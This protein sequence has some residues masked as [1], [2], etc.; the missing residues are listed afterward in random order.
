[1]KKLYLFLAVIFA[2]ALRIMVN[3]V[4]LMRTPRAA[5]N[6]RAAANRF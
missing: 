5:Q 3:T 6:R 2:F 4:F 1:M